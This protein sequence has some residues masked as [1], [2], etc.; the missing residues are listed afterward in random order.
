MTEIEEMIDFLETDTLSFIFSPIGLKYL[1]LKA[2]PD[3]HHI[4]LRTVEKNR[5]QDPAEKLIIEETLKFLTTGKHT[6]PLDLT[7][8]TEFQQNVF[9]AVG[10]VEPG[11]I[12]TYG[13]IAEILGKPGAAQA[14]GSAVAKNPVSY[15]LPTHRVLPKKGIGICRTG[16]GYLREKLLEWEGHDLAK[17]RGNYVCTRRKCCQE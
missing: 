8:F 7:D 17:I 2:K 11:K 4:N 16:A 9:E 12:V 14:V 10:N 5:A 3:L 1:S 6:M 15:F 13:G